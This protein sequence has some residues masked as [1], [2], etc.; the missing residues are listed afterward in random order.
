M[1]FAGI[2]KAA[3]K[4]LHT[5]FFLYCLYGNSYLSISIGGAMVVKKAVIGQHKLAMLGF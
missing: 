1:F 4:L 3:W 2:N 5:V